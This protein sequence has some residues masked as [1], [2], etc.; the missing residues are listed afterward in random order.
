LHSD[1]N[2]DRAPFNVYSRFIKWFGSINLGQ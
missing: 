1:I 2:V